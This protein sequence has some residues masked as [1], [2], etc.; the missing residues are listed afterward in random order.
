M[1]VRDEA[2][3]LIAERAARIVWRLH[4][5]AW[6]RYDVEQECRRQRD[7]ADV[8]ALLQRAGLDNETPI[9]N[10]KED[11]FMRDVIRATYGALGRP[12]TQSGEGEG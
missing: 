12:D 4:G 3:E 9:S 6:T 5:H 1:T 11:R 10:A 8:Q 7:Y 2:I